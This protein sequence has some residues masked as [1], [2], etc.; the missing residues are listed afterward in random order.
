MESE[1]QVM[2][3]I[4][5]GIAA[6]LIVSLMLLVFAGCG[7]GGTESIN[8]V[9]LPDL[10]QVD[11]SATMQKVQQGMENVKN[12]DAAM[13]IDLDMSASAITGTANSVKMNMAMDIQ[14]LKDPIRMHLKVDGDMAEGAGS[15][16]ENIHTELYLVPDGE[17]Y[18][19][20]ISN[21]ENNTAVWQKQTM[22]KEEVEAAM[23]SAESTMN[24]SGN[25]SVKE[26][27]KIFFNATDLSVVGREWI[28]NVNAL[29]IHGEISLSEMMKAMQNTD[30]LGSGIDSNEINMILTMFQDVTVPFD[31]YVDEIANRPV[32]ITMD[33]K[34]AIDEIVSKAMALSGLASGSAQMS[35]SLINVNQAFIS[36]DLKAF[37]EQV[38]DIQVPAEVIQQAKEISGSSSSV[39]KIAVLPNVVESFV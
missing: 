39:D 7:S 14:S 30:L 27:Q 24:A 31:Y 25:A 18:V 15:G 22:K 29:H 23:R 33:L 13:N 4:W 36:M 28:N 1:G 17:N 26:F 32:R 37:D 34:S 8:G 19:A 6:L 35:Q 20:Y 5:K 11:A 9:A 3:R 38:Q 10:S 16:G 2:K 21:V 12:I